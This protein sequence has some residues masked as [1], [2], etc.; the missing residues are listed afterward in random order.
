MRD[1]RIGR[2]GDGFAVTWWQDGKRRRFRLA[3]RTRK[4]AEAEALDVIRRETIAPATATVAAEA[5]A[6]LEFG[7]LKLVAEKRS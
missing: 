6:V 1:F 2:L 3:A 5:A 7:S 4:E